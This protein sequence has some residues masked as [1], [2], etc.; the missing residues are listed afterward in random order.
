[1]LARAPHISQ[2][3]RLQNVGPTVARAAIDRDPSYIIMEYA[4]YGNLDKWM[5]M[6]GGLGP[7]GDRVPFPRT[8]LWRFFDCRE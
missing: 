7:R 8:V 2:Q 1:M 3:F 6:A 4:K 5:R